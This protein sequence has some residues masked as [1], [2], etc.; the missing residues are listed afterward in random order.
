L[1]Q[2]C[3]AKSAPHTIPVREHHGYSKKGRFTRCKNIRH[4]RDGPS[5]RGSGDASHDGAPPRNGPGVPEM[6]TTAPNYVL[7][8][9]LKATDRTGGPFFFSFPIKSLDQR[10]GFFQSR[11]RANFNSLWPVSR[12]RAGTCSACALVHVLNVHMYI[13]RAYF[14]LLTSRAQPQYY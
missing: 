2:R 8:V 7:G 13:C 11:Q 9:E 12:S 1:K 6:R 14:P 10:P 4:E 3:F 5:P